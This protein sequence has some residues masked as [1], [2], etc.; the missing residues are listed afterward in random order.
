[1]GIEFLTDY[2]IPVIMGL[3][4][5]VGY[6]VKHWVKDVDNKIIPTLCAVLGVV[7][8]FWMNWGN[9]TPEVILSGLAS[10]L[11]STGLHQA[12]T[13]LVSGKKDN[14]EG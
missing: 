5:A 11:A 7:V 14:T 9:I 8:A 12:F 1:M 3:C 4:L 2:M 13:Q 6:I 10:G